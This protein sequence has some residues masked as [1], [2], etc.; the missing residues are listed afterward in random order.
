M[1][2]LFIFF[3]LFLVAFRAPAA[4]VWIK[5]YYSTSAEALAACQAEPNGCNDYTNN[6]ILPYC[7]GTG[8]NAWEHRGSHGQSPT[9]MVIVQRYGCYTTSNC[10]SGT[11]LQLDGTCAAPCPSGQV[12][13]VISGACS[14]PPKSNGPSQCRAGVDNFNP[15]NAGTGNKWQHEIDLPGGD[16]LLGF[17]RYYNASTTANASSLGSGWL[18]TY[19]RAVAVSPSGTWAAVT[20]QDG[21]VYYFRQGSYGGWA[22]D[23]D[24]PDLL[25]ELKDSS[26]IRTG[27]RYTTAEAAVETYDAAG[28]LLTDVALS[29][30]T[31]TF[32]YS[33]ASTPSA[34]APVSGLLIRVT[35][36]FGRQL[37]FTYEANNRLNTLTDP[38]GNVTRYGYDADGN[39]TTVT[40][41][42][43]TTSDDT[44]NPTKTYVY[45]EL[46]YTA[47]VSRPHALTGIIDENNA[48]YATFTY[49]AQ[50]R[51][52]ASEHAGG[53][54]R[55]QLAYNADGS[56]TLTDPL[57]T[58][59]TLRFALIKGVVKLTGSD[60]PAGSGCAASASSV[61]YD[62][63]GNISYR[64]DFNGN[65]TNYGYDLSRN[66][67]TS[68][69]EGLTASGAS[70]PATRTINTQWHST[71]RLP[72]KI[73]EPGLETTYTY[74]AKGNITQKKLK[75]LATLRTRIWN[76]AYT[77][78]TA[79]LLLSKSEDGSR[80]DVSDITAFTYYAP[81]AVCVGGHFGC[82]GQLQ[83]ITRPFNQQTRVTRYSANGQPEEIIDSNGLVTTL[84][85]DARQRLV[86]QDV[87]GEGT[88]YSYYPT[89]LV[90]H[91]A[92]PGGVSL[93]Y[94][95]DDAHRLVEIKDQAGNTATYTLD[96][97]GNRTQEDIRDPGGQLART[98]SRIYDALSRLQNLIQTP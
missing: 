7:M 98:Q 10:P 64:I 75:D 22:P 33:D 53:V 73:T 66:L 37:N 24:V 30:Y 12:R 21:K 94:R 76:T 59:R 61:G 84:T 50:G 67:E 31:Q 1:Q 87:G 28:K 3:A 74:D 41:P 63:S 80:T 13:D 82:R 16:W 42:D 68:R 43:Y 47:N 88:T 17:A 77:Y 95:Y 15:I 26:G 32:T 25:V 71:Y 86:S 79:G 55:G 62:A 8:F 96:A 78:S 23:V 70:T 36:S 57:G 34:I 5:E 83:Q 40:Y 4:T 52:I 29:S 60:Q 91:V 44:D 81:N 27:W 49:D 6:T 58:V 90:S 20:R 93:D 39:L 19:Q 72:I 97:L 69:T 18:H 51:A 46:A 54:E 2:K 89:G 56:T 85:Y 65:R 45:G 14:V 38:A 48:R 11:T 92:W 9:N 35:D